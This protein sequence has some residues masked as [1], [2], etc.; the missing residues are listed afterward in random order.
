LTFKHQIRYLD[1][2]TDYQMSTSLDHVG[3]TVSDLDCSLPFYRNLLGMEMLWERVYE[4][5]YVRTL[6]GYPTVRLRCAYLR[7]P[8][9][10]AKVELLE[11]QNVPR[12]HSELHRAD[13]GNAHLALSVPN[14]DA[15]CRRLKEA[16][17]KVVSEP[18]VSTAGQFQGT[19]TVYVQDPD[20]IS[21]QLVEIH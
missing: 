21:I 4:E 2:A 12:E 16:G 3:F 20:G 6:V 1:A 13:P 15:L 11:Y 5:E 18:V 19:K 14:L 10:T 9:S 17:V 7:I 8:G